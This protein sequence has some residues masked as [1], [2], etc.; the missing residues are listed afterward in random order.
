MVHAEPVQ[1]G[2][3][4]PGDPLRCQAV[5][6]SGRHRVVGLGGEPGPDPAGGDPVAD[7]RLAAP[8]AVGV[9]G[10]EVGDA[11]LPGSV[12]HRERLV[13]AQSLAEELRR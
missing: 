7:G 8:A 5:I 1:A 3:Q 11:G 9:G 6:G 4:L 12:H 2:S 13:L 10:V